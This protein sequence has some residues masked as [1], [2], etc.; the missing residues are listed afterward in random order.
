MIHTRFLIWYNLLHSE[1]LVANAWPD[2]ASV[3]DV[4]NDTLDAEPDEDIDLSVSGA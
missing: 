1:E 2:P 3:D 4:T